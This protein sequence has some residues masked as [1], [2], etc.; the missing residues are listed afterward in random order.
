MSV[1]RLAVTAARAI[2]KDGE[3]CTLVRTTGETMGANMKPTPTTSSTSVTALRGRSTFRAEGARQ[4]ERC[5][6]SMMLADITTVPSNDDRI[7]DAQGLTW[8]VA[9]TPVLRVS[10][11]VV[12]VV[13]ERVV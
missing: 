9:G 1:E 10:G 8:E 11:R 3:S 12:D 5:V 4:V 6:F 2:A 7:T 13:C